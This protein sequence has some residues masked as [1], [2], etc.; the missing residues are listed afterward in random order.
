MALSEEG[1]RQ[2]DEPKT[3]PGALV[4]PVR[5]RTEFVHRVECH[6]ATLRPLVS[7]ISRVPFFFFQAEDGIRDYKVTGVQTCALPIF[8]PCV[9]LRGLLA[10]SGERPQPP[11][12]G[13]RRR[14]D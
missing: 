8:A 4:T 9:A 14:I 11:V 2:N 12:A 3:G 13:G 5:R 6:F 10:F 1:R 7:C